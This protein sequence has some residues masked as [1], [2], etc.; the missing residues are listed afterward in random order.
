MQFIDL[1]PLRA[2]YALQ[3]A[4]DY[5]EASVK[6]EDIEK[7]LNLYLHAL[8]RSGE[9]NVVARGKKKGLGQGFS[10]QRHLNS[11]VWAESGQAHL[12]ESIQRFDDESLN[13][14]LYYW[15]AAYVAFDQPLPAPQTGQQVLS[16][17]L[18]HLLQ[19][20]MTTKRILSSCPGLMERYQRLCRACLE[21]RVALVPATNLQR[22]EAA[23]MIECGIRHALGDD[24]VDL[25]RWLEHAMDAAEVGI[26]IPDPPPKLLKENLPFWPVAIW[27]RPIQTSPHDTNLIEDLLDDEF[28]EEYTKK[29]P[30]ETEELNTEDYLDM[31]DEADEEE[32]KKDELSGK[33]VY[34]EWN[35][36]R[37]EYR[38]N[39]CEVIEEVQDN[40]DWAEPPAELYKLARQVRRQFEALRMDDRW[41][42][43]L[44]DG[45]EID[46]DDFIENLCERRGS[47]SANERVFKHR[48]RDDRELAVTVLLD[49]SNSTRFELEGGYRIVDI[50]R[51]A[52]LVLAEALSEVRDEFSI[53]AF[54]GYGR[55]QVNILRL[56]DFDDDYDKTV[57]ERIFSLHPRGSTRI[58]AAL[59][60]MATRLKR[61][62][63][64]RRLLLL[65]TDGRPY[66][67]ADGYKGLYAL[68]DTRKAL[69]E[70]NNDGVFTY[71]LTIDRAGL[72][73]LPYL[74][75]PGKYTVFSNVSALPEFLPKLYARLTGLGN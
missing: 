69:H 63:E 66:D 7:S 58:G 49:I 71:G 27:G 3:D 14:D 51:Q 8:M 75:G 44:T 22:N 34:P 53:Y 43:R 39:W 21:E 70:L 62:S 12:P 35:V 29:N 45:E 38:E 24:S 47:G 60:H 64:K 67:P 25:P 9:Q 40:E 52:M 15:L 73:Y 5:P 10:T 11:L 20:I 6:L 68:E 32:E 59:R 28:F 74:Y 19:G 55:D 50:E 33:F 13:R 36:K 42:R 17:A 72:E 1:L 56:K 61:R 23:Q 65:I 26:V 16:P 48:K 54:S 18:A 4:P 41:L 2:A 37:N 57:K 31:P 46:V 30:E